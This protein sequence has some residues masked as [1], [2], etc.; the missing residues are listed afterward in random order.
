V[1]ASPKQANEEVDPTKMGS[2]R[3]PALATVSGLFL[4][5]RAG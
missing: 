2:L 3:A 1:K 4:V 5:S